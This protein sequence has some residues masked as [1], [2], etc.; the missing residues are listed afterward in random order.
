METLRNLARDRRGATMVEYMILV[1]VALLL[2]GV[3]GDF[4][5]AVKTRLTNGATPSFGPLSLLGL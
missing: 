1:G 4:G 5:T 2:V 3:F